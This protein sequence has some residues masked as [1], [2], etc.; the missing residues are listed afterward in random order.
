MISTAGTSWWAAGRRATRRRWAGGAGG[1]ASAIG[2][3]ALTACA[4]SGGPPTPPTSKEAITLGFMTDWSSGARLKTI[5]DAVAL[6]QARSPHIRVD[7]RHA[8]SLERDLLAGISAGTP[9]DVTLY[10]STS[11]AAQRSSF[12]DLMPFIKRDRFAMGDWLP[13]HP[14]VLHEGGQYGMPFQSNS[15]VWLYN[16]TLFQRHGAPLPTAQWTWNDVAEAAKRLTDKAQQQWGLE[17]AGT[18]TDLF[19]AHLYANGGDYVSQDRKRV[20]LDT[21]E[22]FEAGRW[23]ADR[24]H[25]DQTVV[26]NEE[27]AAVAAPGQSL[28]FQSGRVAMLHRDLRWV[29][30]LQ[31]SIGFGQFEWDLMW[32]ARAPRTGKGLHIVINQP[33]AIPKHASRSGAQQDAA[34]ALTA[35]LSGPE[36]M[37]LIAE[38]RGAVPV[39]R[40]VLTGERYL[41]RPPATMGIVPKL[42]DEGRSVVW[43]PDSQEVFAPV[44]RALGQAWAGQVQAD[45]AL[46]AATQEANAVMAVVATRG[47]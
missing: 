19:Q 16:K 34:W 31:D 13:V 21:P 17:F 25:R 42:V 37:G 41:R 18:E 45:D 11:I 38:N 14:A 9:P 10:S 7:V 4:T 1:A 43:F 36:V 15:G 2:V 6:W 33:H 5:E 20:T 29:G 26:T 32:P 3:G 22:A 12:V 35:F 30:N 44:G 23:I 46:R 8:Q 40:K 39:Y 47:R 27:R 28:A 24:L